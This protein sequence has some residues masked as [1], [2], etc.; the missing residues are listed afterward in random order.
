MKTIATLFFAMLNISV[1]NAQ[2]ITIPYNNTPV[3]I[4][5]NISAGEWAGS[6]ETFIKVSAT[7]SV[8]VL[9]KHDFNAIYF[10]FSGKLESANALFPEVLFDPQ[11]AKGSAWTSGQWWFHVSATDC[12]HNGAYGIYDNCLATQPG[13]EGAPN[14]TMGAPYTDTVEIKI[15]FSK[16]G[17]NPFVTEKMG[18]ALL[19]TNTATSWKL[20]PAI[21]DRNIPSTWST[22]IIGKWPAALHEISEQK[23]SKIYPNPAHDVLTIE[24]SKTATITMVNITGQE[25]LRKQI[26]TG[27]QTL[28]ISGLPKGTY[29]VCLREG[30]DLVH[31]E[32]LVV[33]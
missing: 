26:S 28:N 13:W 1:C 25:L 16:L 19:V 18:M 8:R 20:W 12:E 9:C 10:M 21:A 14:F 3:T 4:D 29:T 27:T 31:Y 2:V 32:K 11:Y 33:E 15:P 7:D 17:I 30:N 6:F 23:N 24:V 5:G 22:A